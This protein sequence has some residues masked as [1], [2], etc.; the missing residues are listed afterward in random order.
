MIKILGDNTFITVT[1]MNGYDA[2]SAPE[3]Q[4]TVNG[5][6]TL[7]RMQADLFTLQDIVQKMQAEKEQEERLL[8]DNPALKDLHDQYRVVLKLVKTTDNKIHGS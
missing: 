3:L 6:A 7:I 5:G 1:S 2:M 4:V 8:A